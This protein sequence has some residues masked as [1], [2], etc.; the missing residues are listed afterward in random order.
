MSVCFKYFLSS[1][2][3]H[4]FNLIKYKNKICINYIPILSELLP[5]EITED[6]DVGEIT[7]LGSL[8]LNKNEF[9]IF[10]VEEVNE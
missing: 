10:V 9:G 1:E 7:D 8:E 3:Y 4:F 5:Y 2:I 6:V